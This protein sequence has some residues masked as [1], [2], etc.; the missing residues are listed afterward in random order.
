MPEKQ[1]L[2]PPPFPSCEATG[3]P[4]G[5]S[6]GCLYFIFR[7]RINFYS[8]PDSV[9]TIPGV[10]HITARN[11]APALWMSREEINV[12]PADLKNAWQ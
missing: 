6:T 7:R 11:Q 9:I 10:W 2:P 1:S 3:L 4:G 5:S 8:F 12:K